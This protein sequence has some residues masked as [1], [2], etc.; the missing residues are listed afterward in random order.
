MLTTFP[1]LKCAIIGSGKIG[2]DLLRK[3]I[4]SPY[5]ECSV[6][7]GRNP[8]SDGLRTAQEIGIKTSHRGIQEIIENPSSCNL[9]FDASSAENHF[10]HAPILK[11]LNKKII[12]ITPSNLGFPC[13]PALNTAESLLHNNVGLIT[14]GGQVSI[15]LAYAISETHKNTQYIEVVTTISSLSAGNA[16]RSNLDEY[17]ETTE[18]A[19]KYF[20]GCTKVK[21]ILILNP[22]SPAINMQTTVFAKVKDYHLDKLNQEVQTMVAKIQEY[23]SGY[24]IISPPV[25][26]N[27][28]IVLMASVQGSGDFL[29]SYSGNLDIINC[30][31]IKIAEE[32]VLNSYRSEVVGQ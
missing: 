29:P 28:R 30:A 32:Y 23:A 3:I 17:I 22:A 5:L 10:K 9:V 15:P 26:D 7:I 19:L 20:T 4:K 12:D 16:T 18:Q 13:I 25:I 14:C 1:K 27:E 31:A 6:F 2:T 11:A 21:A 24:R 8:E